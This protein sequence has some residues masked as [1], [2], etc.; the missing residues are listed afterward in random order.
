MSLLRSRTSPNNQYQLHNYVRGAGAP[1]HKMEIRALP[2]NTIVLEPPRC[3]L[4][5][6]AHFAAIRHVR[7]GIRGR[8]M[9][10]PWFSSD[11]EFFKLKMAAHL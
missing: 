5:K 10:T 3:T 4:Y 7:S 11:A 2:K 8:L 1:K 9:R 6:A